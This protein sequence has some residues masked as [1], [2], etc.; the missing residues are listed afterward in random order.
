MCIHKKKSVLENYIL[1]DY[2]FSKFNKNILVYNFISIIL[3][4]K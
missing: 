1:N 4:Y 3:K 2:L